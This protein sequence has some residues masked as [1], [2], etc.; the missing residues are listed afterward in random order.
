[1]RSGNDDFAELSTKQLIEKRICLVHFLPSDKHVFTSGKMTLL[2]TAVPINVNDNNNVNSE[3]VDN[4]RDEIEELTP[5][6]SHS[7]NQNIS[8]SSGTVIIKVNVST[9]KNVLTHRVRRYTLCTVKEKRLNTQ[10]RNL[11]RQLLLKNRKIRKINAINSQRKISM[12][13]VLYYIDK[14]LNQDQ[15]LFIKMQLNHIKKRKWMQE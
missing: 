2:S 10:I 3:I 13:D 4:F 12:H 5:Q 9:P 11:R 15:L 6:T 7:F 14:N 8:L 1:M